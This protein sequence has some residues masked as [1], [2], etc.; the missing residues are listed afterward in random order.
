VTVVH[1]TPGG[2]HG[3][4]NSL[5]HKQPEVESESHLDLICANDK[6][7]R[8]MPEGMGEPNQMF[9]FH[10]SS[11]ITCTLTFVPPAQS[12][13]DSNATDLHAVWKL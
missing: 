4:G 2:E 9:S 3:K 10:F 6:E 5:R 11:S 7:E 1:V 12:N 13:R 8:Q